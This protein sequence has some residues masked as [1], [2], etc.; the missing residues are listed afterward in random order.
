MVWFVRFGETTY[1]DLAISNE[2]KEDYV[3]RVLN[4]SYPDGNGFVWI[5][6]GAG[7]DAVELMWTPGVP[8][9]FIAPDALHSAG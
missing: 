1:K 5:T 2:D 3:Q 4:A 6:L 9:A 7:E 8:L